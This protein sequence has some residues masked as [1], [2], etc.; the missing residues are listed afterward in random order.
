M[1]LYLIR[2][3]HAGSRKKWSGPDDERPLSGKGRAQ[4][5]GIARW[6]A[7]AG[8]TR[9]LSSPS[10]RCRQTVEPLADRLGL[11]VEDDQALCESAP[12][13]DGLDL[14]QRLTGEVAAVCSHGDVIPELVRGLR[15]QGLRFDGHM[16]SAKGGTFVIETA[17]GRFTT[18]SYVPPP[19]VNGEASARP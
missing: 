14:L 5:A 2:H 9:V 19:D 16:A 10:L 4:A 7:G 13:E 3:G 15:S 8:V 17:D 6:L 12:E 18:C 11:A 1:T